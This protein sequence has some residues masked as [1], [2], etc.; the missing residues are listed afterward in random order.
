MR[1]IALLVV[2][3]SVVFA[4]GGCRMSESSPTIP[5]ASAQLQ[6]PPS[7]STAQVFDCARRR[8]TQLGEAEALWDHPVTREDA[9]QGVLETGDFPEI[10]VTGFRL[11]LR[12]EEASGRVDLRL[13][14]AGAYFV[15]QG[16]DAGLQEFREGF[17]QCVEAAAPR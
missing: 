6:L 2:A 12:H 9:A 13:R 1:V 17:E 8:L 14:G 16:V 3:T 7:T 11:Q 15:D 10:N 4:L 5:E